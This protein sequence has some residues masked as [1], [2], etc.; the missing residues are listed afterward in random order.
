MTSKRPK[1]QEQ[2][3]RAQIIDAALRL[4]VLRDWSNVTM[5]D[6]A[7]EAGISLSDLAR[8]FDG[9][10]DI[11]AAYARR[12][13]ADML[14]AAGNSWGSSPRDA[15]FDMLMER[16]ERLNKDRAAVVSI[17][18][19]FKDDP[20]QM[21]ISLPHLGRSMTWI[22]EAAGIETLGWRGALRVA[23][24]SVVYLYVLRVWTGDDTP[25]MP[26]TMAALDRALAR[27]ESWAGKTG[28]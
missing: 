10:E 28:L 6:I 26:K 22:L 8:S 20:K 24:L 1:K 25:D 23:G 19:S 2:D 17:L 13:D 21:V 9:R 15:L 11:L 14:E 12:I 16:F 5:A 7:G 18:G 3:N 27:V 4:A